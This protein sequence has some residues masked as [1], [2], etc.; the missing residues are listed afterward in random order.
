MP[1][2]IQFH[3][4]L[5]PLIWQHGQMKLEVRIRLLRTAITFYQFLD[6]KNLVVHDIVLTGSNAAFNYTSLSD[7]DIHLIVDFKES[8]CPSLAENIFTTKK[9]L[10]SASYDVTI[11]GHPVELYVE[12]LERPATSNGVYSILEGKW[13]K[14]PSATPPKANSRAIAAKVNAYKAQIDD[15]LASA[16]SKDQI[17]QLFSR[18]R[19]LR[20]NGLENG[21]EFSVENLTY[22]VLRAEGYLDKLFDQRRKAVD[23]DLSL[24]SKTNENV[25]ETDEHSQPVKWIK[26][27]HREEHHEVQHQ[28]QAHKAKAFLPHHVAS[29]LK[30]LRHPEVF[31]NAMKNGKIEHVTPHEAANKIANTGDDFHSLEPEKQQRVKQSFSKKTVKTPIVLHHEPSG[32]KHL[33][34][35]NTRLAYNS[36]IRK[37]NTPVLNLN[38]GH[39]RNAGRIEDSV[40]EN[41]METDD[42]GADRI[43]GSVDNT[44]NRIST[45]TAQNIWI[46]ADG[47]CTCL[48]P[49]ASHD[50]QARVMF[51]ENG[52]DAAFKAG[53]IRLATNKKGKMFFIEMTNS[54]SR[55]ARRQ[56]GEIIQTLSDNIEYL[57]LAKPGAAKPE[58]AFDG[59]QL[60]QALQAIMRF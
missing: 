7:L 50:D 17:D 26:P 19:T 30:R 57:A 31:A 27:N 49:D 1:K 36:Q 13:I 42:R 51:G 3:K 58:Q 46:E 24:P 48:P 21:G 32:H 39:D 55:I 54:A 45:K 47:F 23:D 11:Y 4:K 6:I 16:P 18:L 29:Q 44:I 41:I 53:W 5:N 15:L 25:M 10:W 37:K 33:L 34:A 56:L 59:S 52:S 40:D 2:L 20:Q 12:D 28:L 35:G 9:A 60:R 8:P 22:K 43:D 38:Y 14:R